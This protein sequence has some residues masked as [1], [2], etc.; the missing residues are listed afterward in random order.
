MS[1]RITARAMPS[2]E[3]ISIDLAHPDL[4][5]DLDVLA[6]LLVHVA[7]EEELELVEVSLVLTTHAHVHE[8]NRTY[9]QHDYETDVLSFDLSDAPG[10]IEGEIY[11]DLDTARERHEEFGATFE[12]EAYRYAV[13]GLLHLAGYDDSTP[14]AREYMRSLEDRYLESLRTS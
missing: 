14:D 1:R 5:V 13:H 11:V 7:E 8:L 3:A 10:S 6:K 2:P 9:L 4:A 12:E